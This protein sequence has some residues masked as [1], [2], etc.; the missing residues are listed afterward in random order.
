MLYLERMSLGLLQ[1]SFE[2]VCPA[3]ICV[4]LPSFIVLDFVSYFIFF[5]GVG[6]V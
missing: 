5:L 3:F 1:N 4:E 6:R 2:L